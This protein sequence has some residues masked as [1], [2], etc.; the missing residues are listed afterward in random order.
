MFSLKTPFL[1]ELY[2]KNR[3]VFNFWYI[4]RSI[5]LLINL[6]KIKTNRAT[7]SKTVETDRIIFRDM[8]DLIFFCWIERS[9]CY[10]LYLHFF[11]TLV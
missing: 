9:F 6:R 3:S 7:R 11:H 2:E 8:L 10:I 4:I 5:A 1:K